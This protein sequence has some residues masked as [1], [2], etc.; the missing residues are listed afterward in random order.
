MPKPTII[1][2][3]SELKI[4]DYLFN[5][6]VIPKRD[7]SKKEREEICSYLEYYLGHIKNG[8]IKFNFGKFYLVFQGVENARNLKQ[9]FSD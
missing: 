3:N 8:D 5:L 2:P 7:F 9:Y 6:G 4:D 1:Y